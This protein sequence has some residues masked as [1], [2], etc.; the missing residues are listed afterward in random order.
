[1]NPHESIYVLVTAPVADPRREKAL[2]D[3]LIWLRESN[4]LE[5]AQTGG[6]L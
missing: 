3:L 4:Y 2:D 6:S 1:M 5:P